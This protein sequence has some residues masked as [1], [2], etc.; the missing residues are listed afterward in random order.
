MHS[1]V[2]SYTNGLQPEKRLNSTILMLS[3]ATSI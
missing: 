2:A 3:T 1:L